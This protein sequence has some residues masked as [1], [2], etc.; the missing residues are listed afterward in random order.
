MSRRDAAQN[1]LIRK[2]RMGSTLPRLCF[3]NKHI[4]TA[5]M[6]SSTGILAQTSLFL[7]A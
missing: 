7:E 4:L 1:G 6:S 3:L 2:S 5:G